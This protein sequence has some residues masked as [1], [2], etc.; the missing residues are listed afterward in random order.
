MWAAPNGLGSVFFLAVAEPTGLAD[1][2]LRGAAWLESKL[3]ATSSAMASVSTEEA[4]RAIVP[5][6]DLVASDARPGRKRGADGFES[7]SV[8][9]KS[10][11]V[12]VTSPLRRRGTEGIDSASEAAPPPR[13]S[14]FPYRLL[15]HCPAPVAARICPHSSSNVGGW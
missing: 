7:I 15:V 10:V 13:T 6:L 11:S 4:A 2:G 12:A 9:D 14:A 3:A 5:N 8:V 1:F